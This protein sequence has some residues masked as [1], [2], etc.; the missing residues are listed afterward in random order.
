M[1]DPEEKTSFVTQAENSQLPLTICGSQ[2]RLNNPTLTARDLLKTTFSIIT[3]E[4][5]CLISITLLKTESFNQRWFGVAAIIPVAILYLFMYTNLITGGWGAA[6]SR[7]WCDVKIMYARGFNTIRT[8]VTAFSRTFLFILMYL[9][10]GGNEMTTIIFI[11][12]L[13]VLSEWQAGLSENKNQYD[14]KAHDKFMKQGS[15]CLESLHYFQSQK[16]E[17]S[18]HIQPFIAHVIIK[19]YLITTLIATG[20]SNKN[21][22]TFGIPIV[23]LIVV[24]TYIAPVLIDFAYLKSGITFCQ[25]ELYKMILDIIMPCLIACFTLV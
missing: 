23:S 11:P 21:T 8:I 3:L 5:I 7:F 14:C 6:D 4:T 25:V 13:S 9:I 19:T 17:P 10:L 1:E 15:L 2:C 16:T 22:F 24:Y 20:D 12:L 18:K